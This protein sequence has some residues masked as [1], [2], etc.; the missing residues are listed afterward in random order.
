MRGFSFIMKKL[1]SFV[2]SSSGLDKNCVLEHDGRV[3]GLSA[4]FSSSSGR[5]Y[6]QLRGRQ[7]KPEFINFYAAQESISMTIPLACSLAGRYENL[8]PTRFLAHI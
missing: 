6:R 8:I 3:F 5:Q 4:H 2:A 7:K 1:Y